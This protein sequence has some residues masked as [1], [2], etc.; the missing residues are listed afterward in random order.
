MSPRRWSYE[1]TLCK[2]SVCLFGNF[3]IKINSNS[4]WFAWNKITPF[5]SSPTSVPARCCALTLNKGLFFW[6]WCSC[7]YTHICSMAPWHS[8]GKVC[9][10]MSP[11]SCP[12]GDAGQEMPCLRIPCGQGPSLEPSCI[13]LS[14]TGLPQEHAEMWCLV[15]GKFYR[16]GGKHLWCLGAGGVMWQFCGGIQCLYFAFTIQILLGTLNL[17]AGCGCCDLKYIN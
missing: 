14:E 12:T 9:F 13:A 3:S 6:H 8:Q 11:S 4:N 10:E 2:V 17:N 16:E 15:V 1:S 5:P 7:Y